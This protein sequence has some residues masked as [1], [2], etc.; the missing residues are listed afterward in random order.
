VH[1]NYPV[2]TKNEE[3][4]GAT[5]EPRDVIGQESPVQVQTLTFVRDSVA[6]GNPDATKVSPVPRRD[7]DRLSPLPDRH[8]L[9]ERLNPVVRHYPSQTWDESWSLYWLPLNFGQKLPD[10]RIVAF[11]NGLIGAVKQ[12]GKFQEFTFLEFS[13]IH[14]HL[15]EPFALHAL[16]YVA[17]PTIGIRPEH[18][19]PRLPS[20][21]A[22]GKLDAKAM[23]EM[24]VR[25]NM[26]IR[27]Q[28]CFPDAPVPVYWIR[29]SQEEARSEL[30][31]QGGWSFILSEREEDSF[32]EAVKEAFFKNVEDPGIKAFPV[33]APLLSSQSFLGASRADL[34]AWFSFFTLYL[35]ESIA[36][37][38]LIIGSSVCLDEILV[39][40]VKE[41]GLQEKRKGTWRP[42]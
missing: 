17:I 14:P 37:G 40:C 10:K 38:G 23:G 21:E 24:V 39:E 18:G 11:L 1:R 36:D 2:V 8:K 9:D 34:E 15:T 30:F 19:I 12:T 42:S 28:D 41:S 7:R 16:Q 33:A 26:S 35:A 32:F 6:G 5:T 22:V 27:L 31:G 3:A 20:Q 25:K 4:V 29:A 13:A